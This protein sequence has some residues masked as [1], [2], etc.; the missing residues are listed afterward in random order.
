[1][2][3]EKIVAYLDFLTNFIQ[4]QNSPILSKFNPAYHLF[5]Y[6]NDKKFN[7]YKIGNVS[8]AKMIPFLSREVLNDHICQH[9]IRTDGVSLFRAYFKHQIQMHDRV[10]IISLNY[11]SLAHKALEGLDCFNGFA[12]GNF[13][14]DAFIKSKKTVSYIH[15]HQNFYPS[16]GS[17]LMADSPDSGFK[18]RA[19]NLWTHN[20]QSITEKSF[21]LSFI[22]GD[23]KEKNLQIPVFNTYINKSVYESILADEVV[24]IGY[25]CSDDHINSIVR[26]FFDREK[27]VT[28]VNFDLDGN[29]HSAQFGLTSRFLTR[30]NIT[31]EV[32]KV[33]FHMNGA[34][35]YF[36]KYVINS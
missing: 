34:R 28:F 32:Q 18:Y 13:M 31:Y 14:P 10:S 9:S 11:D 12:S 1:F 19:S 16:G 26:N 7:L 8:G 20:Y 21:G 6:C 5:R 15:G 27:L 30:G 25:S 24:L 4:N 17:I 35:E 36:L 3:F 23:T 22:T 29:T 33:V 2:N